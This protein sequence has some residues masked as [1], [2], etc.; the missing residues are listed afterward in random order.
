ME[1][2]LELKYI[3]IRN[4]LQDYRSRP[5]LYSWKIESYAIRS[6]VSVEAR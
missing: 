2:P 1:V 3:R 4:G 6:I 5:E